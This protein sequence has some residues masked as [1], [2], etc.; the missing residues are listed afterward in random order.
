MRVREVVYVGLDWI[1]LS[2]E[3][4]RWQDSMYTVVD[5]LIA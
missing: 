1:R 5:L 4:I 3:W 2:H